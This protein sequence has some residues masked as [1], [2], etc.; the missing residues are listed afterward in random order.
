MLG[1]SAVGGRGRSFLTFEV[2]IGQCVRYSSFSR[3][4]VLLYVA[5][6]RLTG[7]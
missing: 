6:K 1:G 4:L 5:M 7:L 3:E 2:D